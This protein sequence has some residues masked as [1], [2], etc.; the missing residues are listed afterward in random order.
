MTPM[1]KNPK[2]SLKLLLMVLM[3]G[4]LMI[5]CASGPKTIVPLERARSAY[6]EASANPDIVANAQ[7]P[8]HD[9]KA[10][11]DRAEAADELEEIEHLAYLAERQVQNAVAIAERKMAEAEVER[12][13]QER[14]RIIIEH[15]GLEAEQA[16]IKAEARAQE[17][18]QAKKMAEEKSRQ[19]EVAQQEAQARA[20]E[21]DQAR[22]KA[23]Q[24]E[25]E[26]A[27]LQA[28]Q[29]DRGIV[30]TL[31]D[32][33]FA[34]DEA[35]IQPGA[36]RTI[37]KL[38]EFLH[39]HTE[40]TVVIEGHTDSRGSDVYNL[41]L[42]QQRSDAVRNALVARGIAPARI[43]ARGMGEVYPVASNDTEAGRQ[44][45]RRVEIIISTD[46]GQ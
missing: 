5:G 26:L 13:R 8:M 6:A 22:Q 7:V 10:A 34:Y 38:V 11:L 23:A 25:A 29:T 21:A 1:N 33:L 18:E 24:L 44:Q 36:M 2:T 4:T 17:A 28:K 20:L 31:G 14:N 15:R 39:K 9:A 19:L 40:R 3:L 35:D 41:G 12:L 43:Q 37:D 32:V 45:N 42:S 27:E 16:K 46:A 30:I